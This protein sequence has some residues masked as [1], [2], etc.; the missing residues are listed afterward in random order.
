[1]V[2]DKKMASAG[3]VDSVWAYD[4]PAR[5]KASAG[6]RNL[7]SFFHREL[8][9]AEGMKTASAGQFDFVLTH[10]L[11]NMLVFADKADSAAGDTSFYRH[12]H[13]KFDFEL[14][15]HYL[16]VDNKVSAAENK[17]WAAVELST[18]STAVY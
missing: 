3:Q 6:D 7:G 10:Y 18:H 14:S 1:M 11:D 13:Q 17:N 8:E 5:N 9:A 4:S 16:P 2:E 12:S 15:L